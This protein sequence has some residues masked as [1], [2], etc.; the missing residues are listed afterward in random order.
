[1]ANAMTR[2]MCVIMWRA[3]MHCVNYGSV[4]ARGCHF[5]KNLI[6]G[7]LKVKFRHLGK[8]VHQDRASQ[9]A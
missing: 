5:S 1:M 4:T 3:S 2:I 6:V 9:A 7:V 8:V